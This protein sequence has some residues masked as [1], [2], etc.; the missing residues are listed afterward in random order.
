MTR[1]LHFPPL[2]TA[3]PT[4]RNR[5]YPLIEKYL[6]LQDSRRTMKSK[7]VDFAAMDES[8]ATK[9]RDL[10]NSENLEKSKKEKEDKDMALQLIKRS[11]LPVAH[12][13]AAGPVV[14]V[15]V[16]GQIAFN[17]VTS[18][19]LHGCKLA[20]IGWVDAKARTLAIQGVT[21]VPKGVSEGDL[22]KISISDKAK[23]VAINCA[24]LLNLVGYKYKESG[25]QTF[26]AEVTEAEHMVTFTLPKGGLEPKPVVHRKKKADKAAAPA[27]KAEPEEDEEDEEELEEVEP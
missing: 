23:T 14:A 11:E 25:N 26:T 5:S 8:E 15:R 22:F 6:N 21:K 16:N 7:P 12:N 2:G 1:T 13:R 4:K 9:T 24:G 3:T 18:K 17:S 20:M 27:T 10:E 19:A